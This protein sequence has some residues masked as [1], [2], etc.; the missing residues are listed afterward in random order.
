MSANTVTESLCVGYHQNRQNKHGPRA[1]CI[2]ARSR[3]TRVGRC[4]YWACCGRRAFLVE[5]SLLRRRSAD[6]GGQRL[7]GHPAKI[8]QSPSTSI[9]VCY[10]HKPILR[11]RVLSSSTCP[12]LFFNTNL[13]PLSSN[14]SSSISPQTLSAIIKLLLPFNVYLRKNS[15]IIGVALKYVGLALSRFA[16]VL[17]HE[18]P[19]FLTQ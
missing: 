11:I 8:G 3:A 4:V 2:S 1:T 15:I 13:L 19:I 12:L 5:Q 18:C 14:I 6:L 17:G 10:R 16:T 9:H 7:A